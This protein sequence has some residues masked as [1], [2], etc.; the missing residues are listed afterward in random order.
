MSALRDLLTHP[1]HAAD[2]LGLP[3]PDSPYAVS[4]CLPTWASAVGYEEREP[5]VINALAAGYPRFVYHPLCQRVFDRCTEQH[6]G[7]DR[8]ALVLVSKAAAE[9]FARFLGQQGGGTCTAHDLALNGETAV[10]FDGADAKIAKA[11]WQHTGEGISARQA[12]LI[13]QGAKSD[14]AHDA[15]QTIRERLAR[16]HGNGV[17]AE[18][19]YLF[20][21]GMTAIYTLHRAL[22]ANKPAGRSVQIGFPYVDTLKVLEKFGGGALFFPNHE[23][24]EPALIE[25]IQHN[26]ILGLFTELPSNPL[27]LSPDMAKLRDLAH[28]SG[29]P[30]IIDDTIATCVNADL[31]G[32][33]DVLC[34]SLTKAFSGVGDVAAGALILNP[35]SSH[36][37]RIRASLQTIY[38]DTLFGPDAVVLEA[39]SRDFAER[40]RQTNVTAERLA[41][42]LNAH[43]KVARVHYPKFSSPD[44]YDAL[45]RPAGGYGGL[46]SIDLHDAEN[47]APASFTMRYA[48]AKGRISARTTRWC[49]LTRS[50]RTTTSW[51]GPSRAA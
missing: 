37:D 18:D 20:P 48:A 11:Y 25:S 14:P 23:S 7:E 35:K 12:E 34:T 17:T 40:V 46:M 19:V 47:A 36:A 13:L 10:C 41:D 4:T 22:L 50:W 28:Q 39:N 38:E 5:H 3:I 33:A 45:V 9:R 29:A 6:A 44:R 16:C 26:D 1:I 21:T 32:V 27:L 49:V 31:I 30:L 15:K 51:S 43:P 42:H 8:N 2:E 24:N